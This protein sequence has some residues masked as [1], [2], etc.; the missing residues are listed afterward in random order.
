M[1]KPFVC[2]MVFTMMYL[3]EKTRQVVSFNL[4]SLHMT[5]NDI[6][7]L[8]VFTKVEILL[9]VIIITLLIKYIGGNKDEK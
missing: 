7:I 2:A 4:T 1:I 9:F 8:D 6:L 3:I 5:R